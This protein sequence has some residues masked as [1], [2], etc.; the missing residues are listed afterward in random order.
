MHPFSEGDI[1]SALRAHRDKT[2]SEIG[3]LETDYVLKASPTE[4]EQ[5]FVAEAMIVPLVLHADQQHIERQ[6]GAR[7]DVSRDFRRAIR[8]GERVEV[9]GTRLEIAIPFDGDP[10]LW[11]LRPSRF[12]LSGHPD[13]DIR[14]GSIL[15]VFTFPD[16]SADANQLK[17]QIDRATKSLAEA[18]ATL[19]SDVTQ[20]NNSLPGQVRDCIARRRQKAL[21]VSKAVEGL[22]IPVKRTSTP[23]TYVAPIHRRK[24]TIS[25]PPVPTEKYEPEPFLEESEYQHILSVTRSMG[26]VMERNPRTFAQLDE[27]AI[28]NH[29]LLQLNGHYEGGATG[30]TFNAEGKTDVLIRVNNR[31]VFIA[32]CKFWHGP[33]SFDGAVTQLLGYLSW[34]DSKCALLV[35]NRTK[36]SS[37]VRQKMHETMT[38]RPEFRKCVS[39]APDA[40][41]RYIFVK[42]SDPGR[43]III[44]T[45]LFDVPEDSGSSV[46]GLSPQ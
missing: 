21:A 1:D 34:R 35:L 26:L 42:E 30:E 12:T 6:G 10:N 16:D 31:N 7:I 27:E 3:A 24:V 14:E 45:Q 22:G 8:P 38:G 29:F 20:F 41:A 23:P 40:D 17:S 36:D 9:Q 44:T 37:A 18:V 11:R 33:K 43:E 32:E 15:L 2:L 46:P 19:D 5:H 25:R 4:L 28:R 39:N 13:I